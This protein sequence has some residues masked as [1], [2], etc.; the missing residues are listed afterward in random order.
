MAISAIKKTAN[1]GSPFFFLIAVLR[2]AKR[3]RSGAGNLP[4]KEQGAVACALD[5]SEVRN[6]HYPHRICL[7]SKR[8]SGAD[9]SAQLPPA[10]FS[11]SL[12]DGIAAP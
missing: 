6:P 7:S 8:D 3:P 11:N 5:R 4:E 2:R 1:F 10:R 12:P 9:C